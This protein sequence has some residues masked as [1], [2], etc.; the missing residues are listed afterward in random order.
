M[1]NQFE[2]KA[3]VEMILFVSSKFQNSIRCFGILF[4]CVFQHARCAI[5]MIILSFKNKPLI[6]SLFLSFFI[7]LIDA[8]SYPFDYAIS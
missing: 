6:F 8:S 3:T 7:F 5:L 4:E 1:I 2:A